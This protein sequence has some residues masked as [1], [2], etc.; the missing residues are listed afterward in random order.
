MTSLAEARRDL[1]PEVVER[2]MDRAAGSRPIPGNRVT[3]LFDGPELYPA[4]LQRIAAAERWIH[5]DS[6][7]F[8]GDATGRRFAEALIERARAGV[9][10]RVITDWLGSISTRRRFWR[11]LREAGVEL[12]RFGP[13]HL[14]QLRQNLI[15][16]HRKLLVVDGTTA[17]TGGHCI[18]DE[19]AGKPGGKQQPWRD[20]GCA[21]DGPAAASMDRAFAN[22]WRVMG[23]PLAEAELAAEAP[24][25]GSSAVR[26]IAGEPGGMRASRATDLLLAGAA[27]KV[28]I[29]D[30]YLVAP[31]TIY[32]AL[33]D[34]ARS[35]LDV[36]LLVPG[37]SDLTH[38]QNLTRIGYR[39]LL[40]AGVRIF[41]W[42][43]PMLHAKTMVADGRWIRIGSTNLNFSS[44]L[45][46]YELDV[47]IDDDALGN[48]ME[49]RFRRDLEQCDE[50]GIGAS[51]S[52]RRRR[53]LAVHPGAELPDR[54]YHRPGLRERRR[55]AVVA[56]W[57]VMAGARRT[58]L[59]Q[60]SVALAGLGILFLLLPRV[61]AWMFSVLAL[62]LA[63]SAWFETWG[64][65]RQ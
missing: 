61:M 34:G 6:Y 7:I 15:R 12:R 10:V 42:R 4:M 17:L 30:A 63:L 59:L 11:R 53:K 54:K 45:V 56:V 46:N 43:G 20:T 27:E 1:P 44:L 28:W 49:A 3:L 5:L 26:V 35:G 18:G 33:I 62:W 55:R 48:A 40:E 38:L 64:R 13:P 21:I 9:A 29:T 65:E 16:A 51:K 36:R 2:A 19:W 32:Q 24:A 50:I 60:Y 41:E 31:R 23:T 8:H 58:I 37:T 14:L 22:L 47:L 39:D 52:G 57:T 25:C